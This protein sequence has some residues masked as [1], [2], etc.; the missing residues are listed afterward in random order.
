MIAYE[1]FRSLGLEVDIR[2]VLQGVT[3][4]YDSDDG[5]EYYIGNNFTQPTKIW[6]QLNEEYEYGIER[7]YSDYT[8]YVREVTWMNR[9]TECTKSV[10]LAY[11]TVSLSP[12]L[13]LL[14]TDNTHK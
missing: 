11:Q 8:K 10:Q 3:L 5:E 2:P 12:D 4:P 7:I 1:T 6:S 14:P 13:R 9:P